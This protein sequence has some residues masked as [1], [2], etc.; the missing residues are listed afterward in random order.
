[1]RYKIHVLLT[2][3]LTYY[4]HHNPGVILQ[5]MSIT[6]DFQSVNITEACSDKAQHA[7]TF[8]FSRW[9]ASPLP[10]SAARPANVF[11]LWSVPQITC[12]GLCTALYSG[13]IVN[14]DL[15]TKQYSEV[16]Y[17]VMCWCTVFR[18]TRISFHSCV[19]Q[20]SS[21]SW[22]MTALTPTSS[23]RNSTPC[24]KPLSGHTPIIIIIIFLLFF[25]FF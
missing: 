9:Q 2:Y 16:Q 23:T 17:C 11:L 19:T 5:V 12:D 4:R 22:K 13:R 25:Y 20:S 3:L 6:M 21:E 7:H 18:S 8:W 14:A 24:E 15:Y 10:M 1:M